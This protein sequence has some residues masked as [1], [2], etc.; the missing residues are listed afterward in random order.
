MKKSILAFA[1]TAAIAAVTMS[2][3]STADARCYGCGVGA[4]FLAGAII[5]G[6]IVNSQQRYYGPAP[7]YEY[8]GPPRGDVVAYC[9]DRYKSY[10]P[11]SGTYLGY[12]GY[13]HPCPE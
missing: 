4:G 10:D 9:M 11:R 12:D 13:R 1:A 3:P 2:L 6:A 8:E 7:V 5:G